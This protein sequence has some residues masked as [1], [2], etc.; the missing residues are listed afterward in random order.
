MTKPIN[1][2]CLNCA[3][4]MPTMPR[5]ST[6][7][8][9]WEVR[10]CSRK[11]HHY[12]NLEDSRRAQRERHRYMRLKGDCCVL[13]QSTEELECHHIIPQLQGGPDTANNVMTLCHRCHK[14][15]ESYRRWIEIVK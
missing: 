4:T 10:K 3:V 11:R 12:R 6:K 9:C 14:I 8:P 13:C 7:P 2:K 1:E 15:V 5:D